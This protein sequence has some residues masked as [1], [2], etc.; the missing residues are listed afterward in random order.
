M[1][2]RVVV[3]V[4]K[5]W[6]AYDESEVEIISVLAPA[7]VLDISCSMKLLN[8]LRGGGGGGSV[9]AHVV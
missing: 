9:V 7:P 1:V 2:V 3:L 8:F 6:N 4:F 5:I